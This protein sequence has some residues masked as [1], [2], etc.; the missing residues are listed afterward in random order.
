MAE[1]IFQQLPVEQVD[2]LS[3]TSFKAV[4]GW[5]I[6]GIRLSLGVMGELVDVSPPAR[7]GC[8]ISVRKGPAQV[9]TRAT[10]ELRAIEESSTE[11]TCAAAQEGKRTLV[12]WALKRFQR[13]FALTTFDSIEMRLRG[14]CI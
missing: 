13:D 3:L 14:L 10:M 7:I 1:V 6:A 11:V 2:V 9:S 4:L 8:V 12:A 5:R